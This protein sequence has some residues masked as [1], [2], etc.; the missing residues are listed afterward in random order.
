MNP[1]FMGPLPAGGPLMDPAVFTA[2][3]HSR[4]STVVY[5]VA[6][7]CIA[8]ATVAVA[9]RLYTRQFILKRIGADDYMSIA[10]LTGVVAV[11]ATLIDHLGHGLGWHIWDLALDP[12]EFMEFFK[13]CN[14]A[15]YY[16]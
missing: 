7:L 15:M 1:D 3:D 14:I 10:A 9:L 11:A 16:K 4:R 2:L 5:V 8:L 6:S 13:V 12:L